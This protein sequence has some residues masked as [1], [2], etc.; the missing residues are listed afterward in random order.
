MTNNIPA[1]QRKQAHLGNVLNSYNFQRGSIGTFILN[2]QAPMPQISQEVR[3]APSLAIRTSAPDQG[4]APSSS[5]QSSVI[6]VQQPLLGTDDRYL[7]LLH[8]VRTLF[9]SAAISEQEVQAFMTLTINQQMELYV[10]ACLLDHNGHSERFV[11]ISLRGLLDR[12]NRGNCGRG[13]GCVRGSQRGRG[14]G[15]NRQ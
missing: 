12:H 5:Q 4:S 2:P 3:N 8:V 13:Y 11:A 15:G 7:Q 14:A 10:I 6:P 1:G 9:V